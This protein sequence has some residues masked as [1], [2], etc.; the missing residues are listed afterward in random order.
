MATIMLHNNQPQ[1]LSGGGQWP[2]GSADLAGLIDASAGCQLIW[3]ALDWDEGVSSAPR[4]SHPHGLV[5]ACPR[6]YAK[7]QT[8]R[9]PNGARDPQPLLVS[10]SPTC[11]EPK[12]VT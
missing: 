1:N 8:Q 7:G 10:P 5:W 6:G 4:G 12:Q 2:G 3:D 9:K 11:H